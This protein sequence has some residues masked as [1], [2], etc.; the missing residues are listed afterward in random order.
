MSALMPKQIE[1]GKFVRRFHS[2]TTNFERE[3]EFVEEEVV[4]WKEKKCFSFHI[5]FHSHLQVQKLSTHD[6]VACKFQVWKLNGCARSGC[7]KHTVKM[8]FCL[9]YQ[10]NYSSC[11]YTPQ[12]YFIS[13]GCCFGTIDEIFCCFFLTLN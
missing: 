7:Y 13:D 12:F 9:L 11:L 6:T 8:R 2:E 4:L 1:F 10:W 3:N 5:T